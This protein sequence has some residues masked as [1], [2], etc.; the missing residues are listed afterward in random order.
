MSR[1]RMVRNRAATRPRLSLFPR[2]P[3]GALVGN[4]MLLRA[5]LQAMLEISTSVVRVL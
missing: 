3:G 4:V 5:T 2:R 1:I